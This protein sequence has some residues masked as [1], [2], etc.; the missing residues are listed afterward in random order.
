MTKYK[1][2]TAKELQTGLGFK[3]HTAKTIIHQAKTVM[4][5]KGFGLYN[6]KRIGTVPVWAVESIIGVHLE[7]KE[8]SSNE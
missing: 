7:G 3:E 8:E 4:V 6:N 1:M 5:S 2:I